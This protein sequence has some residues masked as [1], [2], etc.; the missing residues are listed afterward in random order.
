MASAIIMETHGGPEVLTLSHQPDPQAGPGEVLVRNSAVGLNF[1]D[2]YQRKGSTPSR[3]RQ[4]RAAK[5]PA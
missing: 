1:I 3:S 4:Y 5:A 2:I